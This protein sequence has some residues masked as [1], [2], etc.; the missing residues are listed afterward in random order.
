MAVWHLAVDKPNMAVNLIKTWIQDT[1]QVKVKCSSS[2]HLA[3]FSSSLVLV[4][5]NLSPAKISPSRLYFL[6]WTGQIS[7][8]LVAVFCNLG[9]QKRSVYCI[10]V[11]YQI[12]RCKYCQVTRKRILDSDYR[13]FV[14]PQSIQRFPWP[15]ILWGLKCSGP[16]MAN[17][18]KQNPRINKIS[19]TLKAQVYI[20]NCGVSAGHVYG[21]ACGTVWTFGNHWNNLR[22]EE[23]N[24][25]SL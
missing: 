3:G 24:F 25:K 2:T 5:H 22:R 18:S 7:V 20:T 1:A 6:Y 11:L 4:W 13:S 23:W 17:R 15:V 21:R 14:D 12:S 16:L 8:V 10:A 9:S 19:T